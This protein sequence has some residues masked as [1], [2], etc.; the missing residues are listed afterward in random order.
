MS[1]A[2]SAVRGTWQAP[3]HS[4]IPKGLRAAPTRNTQSYSLT[5]RHTPAHLWQGQRV[6]P[7]AAV[8]RE[9]LAA[10][11]DGIQAALHA[12]VAH[13]LLPAPADSMQRMA[14]QNILK[15]IGV[16][17]GRP[18]RWRQQPAPGSPAPTSCTAGP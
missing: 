12:G 8:G 6:G 13:R 10:R 17:S 1:G 3:A 5:R 9:V 7:E 16:A 14:H 18:R 2:V 15:G 4:S 11:G